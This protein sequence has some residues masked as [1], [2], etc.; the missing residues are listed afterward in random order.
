LSVGP[1]GAE[2]WPGTR[3]ILKLVSEAVHSMIRPIEPV[4]GIC[5]DPDDD[6][7]LAC[8]M[9]T[10]A[11]YLVAGDEDLLGLKTFKGVRIVTPRDF[12]MLFID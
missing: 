1:K 5:R 8:A 11:N 6:S 7:I 3:E 9:G 2:L 12:E 10:G 4:A